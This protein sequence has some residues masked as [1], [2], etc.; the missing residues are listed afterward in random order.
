MATVKHHKVVAALPAELEPDAIYYVRV[1]QGHDVYVTNGSGMIVGYPANAALGLAGKVDK[2]EGQS[3]MTDAERAK[4]GGIAPGATA[5]ATDAQLRD[6]STHTGTQAISTI[7]G[8]QTALDA[9]L[10]SA[11]KGAASGVASLDAN[12]KVPLAQLPD[13]I[14]GQVEYMGTWNA[15]TNTPTLPTTPAEKGHYY[16]TSTA[17]SRF[18]HSFEVGDWCI[19][20]GA[21]WDKVDNTDAVSSVNGRAGNVTGLAEATDPRLTDAREWTAT[22]VTQTEAET[23]T[24][25]A[26]RAWTSQRVR[27][28]IAAWWAASAMKTKL[29]GIAVGATANATDA[30]LRDRSTH[31]GSQA[32]STVTGLQTALDNKINTS[33]RGVSGGVATLDEFARIPPSQLPSYVDDVLEYAT[34]AQFPATGEGGK[35]YIAINQGTAANPTRQYR[36]TGSVYAEINP[37]PGTTDALAEG[38]TSLYFNESRVRN[39]V[40]TGLSLASSAAVAATDSVLSA[41]GKIQ[42]QLGLKAPLDSPPLTGNPTAPTAAAND[43]STTI[44]NTAFVRAAMAL[45][46]LGHVSLNILPGNSAADGAP[47]GFYNTDGNTTGLGEFSALNGSMLVLA[48]GTGTANPGGWQFWRRGSSDQLLVRGFSGGTPG[49]WRTL[50]H[51]G[52]FDP[53]TK[54]DK[55]SLVTTAT[56]RTLALTDAWNY[57]RP[58]TTG[59]ITLTVPTNAAVA[60]DIG[61]EITIRALGNVTLAAA[62]GVTLNAPSGGTLSMTASMTVTLKKVAA[63]EWDVIGQTVAA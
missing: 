60:F 5:N 16:V 10:P 40:L 53:A 56:S 13:S 30:Q 8:L 4:L 44:A 61:T 45:F 38:S 25:T 21:S 23:G 17:G 57:L 55:S 32:I 9:K 33:E 2:V 39:T 7:G 15:A 6:R 41:L 37:S 31:T 62:S 26:R 49:P 34:T 22:T 59:A 36:W 51:D 14:I 58:N 19:S 27:Q 50:Y 63:N 47:A 12:A 1:G 46:G 24:A 11:Q 35:I 28:A 29:D 52:N 42:A 20:N 48:R 3:L 18:G 54:Q 43:N